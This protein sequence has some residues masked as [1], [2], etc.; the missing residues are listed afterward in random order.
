MGAKLLLTS[1]RELDHFIRSQ[2]N[3]FGK[4][5][6]VRVSSQIHDDATFFPF[7]FFVYFR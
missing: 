1:Q 6:G 5:S 3:S 4:R 7:S 2:E